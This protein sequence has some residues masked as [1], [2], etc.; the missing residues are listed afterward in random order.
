MQAP[1]VMRH[2]MGG[3]PVQCPLPLKSIAMSARFGSALFGMAP[4]VG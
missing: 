2:G 1:L 4:K 3:G